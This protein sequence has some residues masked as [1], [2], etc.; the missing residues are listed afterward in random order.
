MVDWKVGMLEIS[1]EL[2]KVKRLE[3]EHKVQP[4][5]NLRKYQL[6]K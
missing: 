4:M 6:E 1:T 3:K 5:V 2:K